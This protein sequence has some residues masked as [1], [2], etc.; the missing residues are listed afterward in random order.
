[1]STMGTIRSRSHR[2]AAQSGLRLVRSMIV[3]LGEGMERRRTRRALLE[4]TEEQLK[5]IG[6]SRA[7]AYGEA[8][9]PFWE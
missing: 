8:H 7:D 4:M 3:R 9:R 5:D 6:L 1:M 2:S